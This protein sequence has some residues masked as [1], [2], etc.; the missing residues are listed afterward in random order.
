MKFKGIGLISAKHVEKLTLCIT[1]RNMHDDELHAGGLNDV[2]QMQLLFC[3]QW[4][5]HVTC[6][7]NKQFVT[8]VD[9][10]CGSEGG[11]FE[12]IRGGARPVEDPA[13]QHTKLSLDNKFGALDTEQS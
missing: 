9:V 6:S 4:S 3:G 10:C 1:N 7:C 8:K 5:V 11:A 13:M 12:K 2:G